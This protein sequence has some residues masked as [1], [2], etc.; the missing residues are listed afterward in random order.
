MAASVSTTAGDADDSQQ[1]AALV[2]ALLGQLFSTVSTAQ[3]AR[4]E[5]DAASTIAEDDTDFVEEITELWLRT[6]G[7]VA[8]AR[9]KGN[10]A[11]AGAVARSRWLQHLRPALQQL[12]DDTGFDARLTEA[13]ESLV[14]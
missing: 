12:G 13:L 2:L 6:V 14:A 3:P 8:A 9:T 1:A 4:M 11:F 5:S 10:A 7:I